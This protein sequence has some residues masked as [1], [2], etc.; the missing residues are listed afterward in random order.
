MKEGLLKYIFTLLVIS[1]SFSAYAQDAFVNARLDANRISVGDQAKLFLEV[2]HKRSAGRLQ[3]ANIPDTFNNLEI[4]DRGRID[5]ITKGDIVTYK[6]RLLVTGFDSGAHTIPT[7]TF[8]VIPNQGT[9][10]TVQ[11]DSLSLLV[12]TVAVD[13]SKAFR[14]IKEIVAVQT[15]WLDYI[16]YIIGALVFIILGIVVARYFMRNKKVPIPVTTAPVRVE[17]LQEK[18]LRYLSELDKKQLWQHGQIKDYYTELTEILRGY[19]ELRYNKP[20]MELTTDELLQSARRH[21]EMK[22]YVS[23]LFDVLYTADMA[24]FAKAQPL[25]QEHVAALSNTIKFVNETTPKG[26]STAQ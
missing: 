20:A 16:W 1:I 24:K 9:A 11:S 23:I 22:Q 8:P 25:P 5:T 12:Q 2:Q 15:T 21:H 26:D 6:Q 18:T 17:T 13:T 10:Y 14:G 4:V 3:W 19:I 7:F